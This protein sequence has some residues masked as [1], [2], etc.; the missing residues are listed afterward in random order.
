[1]SDD[2]ALSSSALPLLLDAS[3]PVV[4]VGI[5][6]PEG[7]RALFSDEKPALE[8]LFICL[9]KCLEQ[10]DSHATSIDAL[11]FC[12]GPGSTLGLRIAAT[13]AK[14]IL[15]ENE[16]SPILYL[17][18]ALDL[19]ALIVPAHRPI[20]APFRKGKRLLRHPPEDGSPLGEI[21]VLEEDEAATL[22]PDA[23][24]LPG[25]RAWDVIPKGAETLTYD[26][27]LL[28]GGLADLAPIL[29]PAEIPQVFDP[30]PAEFRKWEPARKLSPQ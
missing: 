1:M 14:T 8:S 2:N 10:V 29:R 27:S 15:H 3:G 25:P 22:A 21:E 26:L 30:E 28:S 12:E 11:L 5:P 24:H 17:Y 4:Q 7:W 16:P 6:S 19:A 23:I 18:N 20:L 13:A 9:R